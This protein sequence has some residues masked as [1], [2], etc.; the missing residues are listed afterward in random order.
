MGPASEV[1]WLLGRNGRGM[2]D[3]VFV[4]PRKA[5]VGSTAAGGRR[6]ALFCDD[7][8]GG[9]VQRMTVNLANHLVAEAF[10]V[11]LLLARNKGPFKSLLNPTVNIVDLKSKRVL[12]SIP[13]VMRY[14]RRRKPDGMLCAVTNVN[15]AGVVARLLSR[16]KTR[17]V[18]SERNHLSTA[19]RNAPGWRKRV[20]LPAL[21]RLLYARADAVVGISDGVTKDLAAIMDLPQALLSTIYNPVVTPDMFDMLGAEVNHPWLAAKQQPV[22]V[23][24]GRLV[25]QKDYPTLLKAFRVLREDRPCRLLILGEGGDRADLEVLAENLGIR[26]DVDFLGFVANPL[27]Y[28]AKCDV[29]VL[30]SAWEGFGNVLVEA[31]FCGLSIVA[32]DCPSGPAEILKHGTYGALTPVGDAKALAVALGARLD[33][34]MNQ[35]RQQERSIDFSTEVIGKQYLRLLLDEP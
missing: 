27:A 11:D 26:D 32:T 19:S 15:I 13:A 29:F 1:N 28:M 33:N 22:L 2:P 7:L 20:L 18:I 5:A 3:G 30:A 16:T 10:E 31:L 8:E 34:P 23:T 17:I 6:L 21:A 35:I 24:S 14:L 9:G 4:T 12:L 25:P